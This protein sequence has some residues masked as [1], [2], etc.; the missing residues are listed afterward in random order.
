MG[1]AKNKVV[2]NIKEATGKVTGDR[3]LEARGKGQKAVGKIQ[4]GGRKVTG[5][6]EEAIGRAAGSP[7]KTAKGRAKR[8]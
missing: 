4:E 8:T 7:T 3:R 6:V 2:G 1:E 5:T